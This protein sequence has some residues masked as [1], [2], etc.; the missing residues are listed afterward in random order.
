MNPDF[1]TSVTILR[2]KA[3]KPGAAKSTAAVNAAR[4]RGDNIS[5]EQRY[6]AGGNRQHQTTL[7]TL[8]LD[9]ET[10]ELKH[11]KV[12]LSVGKLIMQGRQA[13]GMT[14]KELATKICEKPQVV[15][16]YEAGKAVPN[17]AI[18]GKLERALD[19]KLRGKDKGQGLAKGPKKKGEKW[20]L[21]CVEGPPLALFDN[22]G[23][24]FFWSLRYTICNTIGKFCSLIP[25]SPN[26]TIK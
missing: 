19:M 22:Q 16:D 7:N 12:S 4:R 20:S 10:E 5:T 1:N 9:E 21:G 2:G 8:R 26:W 11:E 13:K 24:T 14:Q 23:A 17:Q 25:K 3:P 6:G 15:N 18:L